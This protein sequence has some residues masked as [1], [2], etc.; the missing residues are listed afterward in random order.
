MLIV[1]LKLEG[2]S[3]I[4]GITTTN[5][6]CLLTSLAQTNWKLTST[7]F[8]WLHLPQFESIWIM[9]PLLHDGAGFRSPQHLFFGVGGC[10]SPFTLHQAFPLT[11]HFASSTHIEQ[12]TLNHG[13]GYSTLYFAPKTFKKQNHKLPSPIQHVRW[14]LTVQHVYIQVQVT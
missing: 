8:A 1:C 6:Y 11:P 2:C 10:S 7:S 14:H 3:L 13:Y 12:L 5:C 4:V 9:K